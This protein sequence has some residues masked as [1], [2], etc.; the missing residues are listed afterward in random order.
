MSVVA[1]PRVCPLLTPPG[2]RPCGGSPSPGFTSS[3]FSLEFPFCG[4]RPQKPPGRRTWEPGRPRA[5][6]WRRPGA[7]VPCAVWVRGSGGRDTAAAS[8][9]SPCPQGGCPLVPALEMPPFLFPLW[10][11]AGSSL[12]PPGPALSRCASV[13]G[14]LLRHRAGREWTRVHLQLGGLRFCKTSL[15]RV[16][17][18]FSF[19]PFLFLETP[20]F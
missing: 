17:L 8:Q 6:G 5:L 14:I 2:T 10:K 9:A 15:C 13:R 11:L 1:G 3:A 19:S 20:V 18:S 12:H 4:T 16:L 7:G